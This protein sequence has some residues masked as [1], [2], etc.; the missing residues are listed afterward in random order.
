MANQ[1]NSYR[2][3]QRRLKLGKLPPW[4]QGRLSAHVVEDVLRLTPQAQNTLAAALD[5]ELHPVRKACKVLYEQPDI[6]LEEL[7]RLCRRTG[8]LSSLSAQS[9]N[10]QN[11]SPQADP[12]PYLLDPRDLA[13]LAD[14]YQYA[15]P[16]ASRMIAEAW[17][18]SETWLPILDLLQS[19][20]ELRQA[21]IFRSDTTIVLVCGFALQLNEQLNQLLAQNPAYRQALRISGVRWPGI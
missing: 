2:Q 4:L 14:L 1:G 10:T 19:W 13:A 8:R 11:G 15:H 3:R 12:S 9:D 20:R 16:Q 21:D 5:V 17:A 7:L 6:S 18:E